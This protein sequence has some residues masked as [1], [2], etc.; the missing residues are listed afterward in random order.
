MIGSCN[1]RVHVGK[2]HALQMNFGITEAIFIHN[3]V[4]HSNV[5]TMTHELMEAKRA[6][7]H[8]FVE[9][10][11]SPCHVKDRT[12]RRPANGASSRFANLTANYLKSTATTS[13]CAAIGVMRTP[14]SANL[15]HFAAIGPDISQLF[16]IV[17]GNP[18]DAGQFL[19][20]VL[21]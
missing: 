2:K 10:E 3:L 20:V 1:E 16:N 7:R 21:C 11:R 15:G 17:H 6:T 18:A 8:A 9:H 19:R 14:R 4:H 12:A 5:K 13:H